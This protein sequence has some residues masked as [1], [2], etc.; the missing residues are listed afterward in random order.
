MVLNLAGD[1]PIIIDKLEAS[2]CL[3]DITNNSQYLITFDDYYKIE[4]Y[5]ENEWVC[6]HENI[7]P[8]KNHRNSLYYWNRGHIKDED[9]LLTDSM[10]LASGES[11]SGVFS[12]PFN[13][14]GIYRITLRGN[15]LLNEKQEYCNVSRVTSVEIKNTEAKSNHDEDIL[16][17]IINNDKLDYSSD[18]MIL[19]YSIHNNT[20]NAIHVSPTIYE[21]LTDKGWEKINILIGSNPNGEPETYEQGITNIK[22]NLLSFFPKL[23]KG[24]YRIRLHCYGEEEE[25]HIYDYF[26][27]S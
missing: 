18:K 5:D 3:V 19:N 1:E 14:A 4:V 27:I 17:M 16:F 11:S 21:I 25:K 22:D 2:V 26:I 10:T 12:F 9:A 20:E 13:K 8:Q 24:Q 15:F 23:D 6:L 7:E